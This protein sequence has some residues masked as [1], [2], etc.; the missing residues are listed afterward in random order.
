MRGITANRYYLLR[1][2]LR[3]LE[4]LDLPEEDRALDED[5][6]DRLPDDRLAEDFLEGVLLEGAALR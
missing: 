4:E 1:P 5:G 2:A 3:L 6:F